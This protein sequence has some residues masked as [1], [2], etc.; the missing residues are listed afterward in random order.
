MQSTR[1]IATRASSLLLSAVMGCS[2][3]SSYTPPDSWRARPIYSGNEIIAIG[4]DTTVRCANEPIHD[5]D[6]QPLPDPPPVPM[7]IDGAGYWSP[8]VYVHPVYFG[9]HHHHV[10][11]P[12]PGFVPGPG[13]GVHGHHAGLGN[14]FGGL[15]GLNGDAA[16][17]LLAIMLAVGIA[18]SSGVAVGFAAA[19]SY[20]PSV[21]DAIDQI[22]AHNDRM[23]QQIAAC[24]LQAPTPAPV[25]VAP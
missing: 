12:G 6:P 18:V 21:P 5:S 1:G 7:S 10:L 20:S 3:V 17:Y 19:P 9:Y 23:R 15:N 16:G 13:F 14:L 25:E 2:Y 4:T 24:N 22:N 11:L 8:P